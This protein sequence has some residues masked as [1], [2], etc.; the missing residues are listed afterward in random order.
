[1][2]EALKEDEIDAGILVTPL[3]DR[4]IKEKSALS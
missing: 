2:I 4:N 1:M 3:H